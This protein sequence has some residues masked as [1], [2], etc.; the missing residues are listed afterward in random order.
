MQIWERRRRISSQLYNDL[1]PLTSLTRT[2][3]AT[4]LPKR[5]ATHSAPQRKDLARPGA[6]VHLHRDINSM[7]EQNELVDLIFHTWRSRTQTGDHH[8]PTPTCRKTSSPESSKY[9]TSW[10]LLRCTV[11]HHSRGSAVH[12]SWYMW[13]LSACS[14]ASANKAPEPAAVSVDT[15]TRCA[16]HTRCAQKTRYA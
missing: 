9:I 6:A 16:Q 3:T 8:A 2:A 10:Y 12:H 4:C 15:I 5:S 1:P 14:A 13:P 7:I 11:V